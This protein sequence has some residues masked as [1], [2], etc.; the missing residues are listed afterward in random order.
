[1]LFILVAVLLVTLIS[2]FTYLFRFLIPV[3]IYKDL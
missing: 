3:F 1:M 2:N